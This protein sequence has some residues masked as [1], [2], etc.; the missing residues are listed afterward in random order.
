MMRVYPFL[1]K[2]ILIGCLLLT[3]S[4]HAEID[5]LLVQ[6]K[7]K[8]GDAIEYVRQSPDGK[9]I[10]AVDISSLRVTQEYVGTKIVVDEMLP[11]YL[12]KSEK[13]IK[14]KALAE[15]VDGIL[16]QSAEGEYSVFHLDGHHRSL[17]YQLYNQK[18]QAHVKM[19]IKLIDDYTGTVGGKKM[20]TE[21]IAHDLITHKQ[22]TYV[23]SGKTDEEKLK[24]LIDPAHDQIA[25][26]KNCDLRTDVGSALYFLNWKAEHFRDYLEFYIGEDL[27]PNRLGCADPK[28]QNYANVQSESRL[29]EV[30]K[31]IFAEPGCKIFKKLQ[32]DYRRVGHERDALQALKEAKTQFDLKFPTLKSTCPL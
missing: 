1:N 15:T 5:S 16:F 17:T 20:D 28:N 24:F 23:T 11:R 30:Q 6:K 22:K 12:K 32:T 26:V 27:T 31:R 4:A 13:K 7:F 10:V 3:A 29:S 9:P 14:K 8:Q 18:K 21:T 19:A 2:H 25:E